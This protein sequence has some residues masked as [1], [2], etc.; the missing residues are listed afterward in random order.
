MKN[1]EPDRFQCQ[2][3]ATKTK[4]R[5]TLLARHDNGGKLLCPRHQAEAIKKKGKK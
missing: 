1:Y 4:K 2:H 5:C 3:I